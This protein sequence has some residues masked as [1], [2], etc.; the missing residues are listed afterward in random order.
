MERERADFEHGERRRALKLVV[1]GLAAA[2]SLVTLATRQDWIEVPD[3]WSPLATLRIDEEPSLLTRFKLSRLSG[4]GGLCG[5]VLST[6]DMTFERLS[7]RETGPGCRFRDAVRIDR[8]TATVGEPFTLTCRAAV[9]LALWERHV[10]QPAALEYLG[11]PVAEL[12]HFGSYACRNIYNRPNATR[13]R[14]ATAEAVDIA[15]FVLADGRRVR[16]V[17]DWSEDTDASRFLREVRDGA[18]GFFDGV[19]SPDYNAAHRDH[20]HLDRGSYRMCR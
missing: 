3:R 17:N 9:S 12:E 20:L 1:T 13:S 18:C 4:D 15:G 6:A 10:L 2:V 7:D 16:V 14:H 11:A 8:T 5:S 19:L